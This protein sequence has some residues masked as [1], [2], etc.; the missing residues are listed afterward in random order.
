MQPR[1]LEEVKE[2]INDIEE[3]AKRANEEDAFYDF[4]DELDEDL[5]DEGVSVAN[6]PSGATFGL[7]KENKS[8]KWWQRKVN[9]L[10]GISDLI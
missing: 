10:F 3:S 4:L 8:L 1:A 2:D 6:M 7:I 9:N 5:I